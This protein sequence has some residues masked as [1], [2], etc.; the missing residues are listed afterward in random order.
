MEKSK[1][2]IS[3]ILAICALSAL[4]AVGAVSV[5]ADSI[6]L[7]DH[8]S[9]EDQ[10]AVLGWSV[11]PD[12]FFYDEG[13]IYAV[14]QD[15]TYAKI[16]EGPCIAY[17]SQNP[18]PFYTPVTLCPSNVQNGIAF[19]EMSYYNRTPYYTLID[20]VGF[21]ACYGSGYQSVPSVDNLTK[22]SGIPLEQRSLSDFGFS[23]DPPEPEIEPSDPSSGSS[24]GALLDGFTWAQNIGYYASFSPLLNSSTLEPSYLGVT[25][26]S[27][28]PY[29]QITDSKFQAPSS[30]NGCALI[31]GQKTDYDD[32]LVSGT[33]GYGVCAMLVTSPLFK[34]DPSTLGVDYSAQIFF[35]SGD[36]PSASGYTQVDASTLGLE[37]YTVRVWTIDYNEWSK[38][39]MCRYY[40]VLDL[41][42]STSSFPTDTISV[43][44]KS[45]SV[46]TH[47]WYWTPFD[48]RFQYALRESESDPLPD[49]VT[50]Y[51]PAT[52]SPTSTGGYNTSGSTVTSDLNEEF[53]WS[54]E[55]FKAVDT[56]VTPIYEQ[57]DGF[58]NFHSSVLTGLD[59]LYTA[60]SYS[61]TGGT[62]T[63]PSATIPFGDTTLHLWD[64][65][66]IPF[67]EY[68]TQIP[69]VYKVIISFL[70]IGG[71]FFAC[72]AI[73]W[74]FFKQ[75]FFGDVS[76]ERF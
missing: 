12:F 15:R 71:G 25:R 36:D 4:C 7:H 46:H 23:Y 17:M 33:V 76:N 64:Q 74:K 60:M 61:G 43:Q 34:L 54:Q 30:S 38:I 63:L 6:Q 52:G 19:V 5:S 14:N 9:R 55:L 49:S 1:K 21:F 68:I 26:M 41:G 35:A 16:Y 39:V 40:F 48:F 58:Y 65:Q 11:D 50:N 18:D 10:Y 59:T 70:L 57:L 45:T 51:N 13:T 3:I 42:V 62:I 27:R 24:E 72:S 47:E 31:M 22:L 28:L 44:F 37:E 32:I 20:G 8:S 67:N 53:T 2:I 73:F 69:Q 56:V 29:D 75:V 66:T